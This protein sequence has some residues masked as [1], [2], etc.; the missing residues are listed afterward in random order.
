MI[1]LFI[2]I[3][4][5]MIYNTGPFFNWTFIDVL[6]EEVVHL[7]A[8]EIFVGVGFVGFVRQHQRLE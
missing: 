5:G 7:G 2:I 4:I 8:S 3:I 6:V 1:I